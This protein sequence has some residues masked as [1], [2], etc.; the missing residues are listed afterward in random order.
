MPKPLEA[1]LLATRSADKANEVRAILSA[2]A[3]HEI[4]TLSELG[5]RPTPAE[6]GL[7]VHESFLANALAKARYFARLTGR[8]VLTDDSGIVVDALGGAPG[9]RSK[10]FAGRS[11][12][13]GL[14]LDHANNDLLLER[15]HGIPPNQRAAHYACAA[16]Y[17]ELGQPPLFAIATVTGTIALEPIGHSGFGYDP[18]FFFP[19]LGLTFAQLDD[20]AKN[21]HSHRGRAFRALA[22][23]ARWTR[24][25]RS[26]EH[27]PRKPRVDPP[28]PLA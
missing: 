9:V 12:L 5:V 16:V 14:D 1:I 13:A 21:R 3:T 23:T 2:G 8:P 19:P 18:I 27:V 6:D 20:G 17:L 26:A 28:P 10:R 15:L 22:A 4:R 25:E 24:L 7:E 11:D